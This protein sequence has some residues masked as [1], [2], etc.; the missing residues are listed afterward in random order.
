MT[1]CLWQ[2]KRQ[3]ETRRGWMCTAQVLGR[4]CDE[5]RDGQLQE[6][7]ADADADADVATGEGRDGLLQV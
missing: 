7:D 1:N 6:A 3:P 5:D 2:R 4:V